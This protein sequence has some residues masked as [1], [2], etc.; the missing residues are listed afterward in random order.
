MDRQGSAFEVAVDAL[1][2]AVATPLDANDLGRLAQMHTQCQVL[3]QLGGD[4]GG[5]AQ[6][7]ADL[8]ER[9]ILKEAADVAG[10]LAA[11]AE[12]V[13]ALADV[14]N[15]NPGELAGLV[16]RVRTAA[17]GTE[18]KSDMGGGAPLVVDLSERAQL[19][20]FVDE[21]RE[22][23][24]TVEEVLLE[25]ERGA[26]GRARI[27]ELFRAFHTI[28]GIAGFLSLHNVNRLTHEAETL[29]DRVRKG[30]LQLAPAVI[31]VLF[32][33]VDL[34][35]KQ[36]DSLAAYLA[37]PRGNV[38]PQPE[39]SEMVGQ[40]RALAA[41]KM[42]AASSQPPSSE[43]QPHDAG[44]RKVPGAAMVAETS[45]RVDTSKLD[46][47]VDVVGELVVAQ[48]MVGANDE[49]RLSNKLVHDVNRLAKIVREVQESAMALRMV[50]IGQ[51]FQ[52]MRRL[53]RDVAHKAG[54]RVELQLS[55]A[56]IEL[57]KNM[58]QA[59]SDPLVHMVRNAVDHGLE[60]PAQREAAGK[61]AVGTVTLAAQQQGDMVVVEIRDDGRGLDRER[62]VAKAVEKGLAAPGE[63]LGDEQICEL[64]MQPGFSTAQEVTE[65]SGRGVGLDVVRRNVEQ[66]RGKIDVTTTPGQGTCF[67][68]R[69]PLTLSIIDGMLVRVGR[70]RLIIPVF[71]IEQSLRPTATQLA[72]VQGDSEIVK[73]RGGFVPL[74]QLGALFGYSQAIDP[75][76]AM[77][78]VAYADEQ[79]IGLVVDEL[80]GQQQVVVKALGDGFRRAQGISGAAILSDGQVGLILDAAGVLDLHAGQKGNL[81]RP[82]SCEREPAQTDESCGVLAAGPNGRREG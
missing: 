58:I 71:Q 55:G 40:L 75:R 79:R 67:R 51:T 10:G 30:T 7:V 60:T 73:V 13:A 5:L 32:G 52:R 61:P 57:D 15:G 18:T 72:H 29:L 74:V 31:E 64:I 37:A 11:I 66:L 77:V 43:S 33:V 23:L 26:V 69:L 39:I 44:A 8:L 14:M 6:A 1:R 45:I 46:Q 59:M 17:G 62:L 65:I 41:T 68:L 54:K 34:L 27:D 42:P 53:V 21:G 2:L 22:H 16:A 20:G 35:R 19:Q 70:E 76:D 63:K 56:E 9:L 4:A 12:A 25:A 82:D 78:V 47:L 28:K 36:I 38:V 48:T 24:A 49:L 81:N 3:S 80:L 50:P